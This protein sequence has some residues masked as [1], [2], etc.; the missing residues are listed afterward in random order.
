MITAHNE[1]AQYRDLNGVP[2]LRISPIGCLV[3]DNGGS[4]SVALAHARITRIYVG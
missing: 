4:S 1:H 2:V 3:L